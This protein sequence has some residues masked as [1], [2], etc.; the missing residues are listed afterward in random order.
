MQEIVTCR[1][2]DS[3]TPWTIQ[4]LPHRER[5]TPVVLP[6]HSCVCV[7][8]CVC[9]CVF[10]VLQAYPSSEPASARPKRTA[11]KKKQSQASQQAEPTPCERLRRSKRVCYAESDS[12]D[13]DES[14]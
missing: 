12:D 13:M 1:V 7:C 3:K 11:A 9:V 2:P 14:Q 6:R 4:A 8:A 10:F 5:S